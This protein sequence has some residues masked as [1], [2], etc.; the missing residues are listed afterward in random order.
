MS[1]PEP[2]IEDD[3][4]DA[5][6]D[7]VDEVSDELKGKERAIA[8]KANI[9]LYQILR[10]KLRKLMHGKEDRNEQRRERRRARQLSK[11]G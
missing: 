9:R 7:S 11:E 10:P 8:Q 6:M 3:V 5:Y 1:L 4:Y 2:L